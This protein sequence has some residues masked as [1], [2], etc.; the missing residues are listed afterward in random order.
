M[1]TNSSDGSLT[2][3]IPNLKNNDA[4]KAAITIL[5]WCSFFTFLKQLLSIVFVIC[6]Y[7]IQRN[8]RSGSPSLFLVGVKA[9]PWLSQTQLLLRPLGRSQSTIQCVN[10]AC[11]KFSGSKD[12]I[13]DL[14][15]HHGRK[16]NNRCEMFAV[17]YMTAAQISLLK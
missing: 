5:R 6:R 8:T 17:I 1:M 2:I 12:L 4:S 15:R 13:N 7:R 3:T 11:S 10:F 9:P 16:N 14:K